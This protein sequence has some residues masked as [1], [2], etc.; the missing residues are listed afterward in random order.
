MSATETAE[1]R[2][3]RENLE[4]SRY[5]YQHE[6]IFLW[7]RP[8]CL[9][10]VLG[11]ACNL[12]CI[13][14]YQAKNGDH[15]LRPAEIGRE[16]R[17]EF[18]ALYPYV[19]TL[20]VMGGEVLAM[21]GFSELVEDVG[22]A[23]SRPIL[24]ISTNGTLLDNVWAEKMVRLPFQ[25][26]TVS[27]DA[28]TSG[29][30]MKLRGVDLEVILGG[31]GRLREWKTR[32]G[33]ELPHLN[34]FF[35]VMRSNFREIPAYLELM[36]QN[37]VL[38]VAFQ[39]M[40]INRENA[41]RRPWLDAQETIRSAEE[42]R[43]L[44]VILRGALERE[45]PL[46]RMIRVSGL[47]WLFAAHG[48][49]TSF[50]HEQQQGLYPNSDD[51][52]DEKAF[53]CCPNPWTT[54]FVAENGGVHLCFISEPIANIYEMPL[55]E[56]W[57]SP[58]AIAKRSHMLAGRYTASGCSKSLCGWRDG[59]PATARDKFQG[60][61]A[62]MAELSRH[63]RDVQGVAE[64]EPVVAQVRRAFREKTQSVAELQSRFQIL[65]ETNGEVHR[66]GQKYIDQLEARINEMEP[67]RKPALVRAAESIGRRLS[68]WGGGLS[69]PP[70]RFRAGRAG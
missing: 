13:H 12:D 60:S 69:R 9:G 47:E 66:F 15:L 70:A 45:R 56:I 57:N 50:L 65:C 68:V 48:L 28:A 20:R 43:E 3:Y 18:A 22:A 44:H 26:V 49:E 41:G 21:R 6:R 23:V 14:C 67:R 19:S 7:S 11:N 24:S 16:L 63:A 35:V 4:L 40:D 55:A 53:E 29:T 34:S 46:F 5:E 58:R 31:I 59:R 1:E 32:L 25:A 17:R 64:P 33:S 37:G 51:L 30:M 8:R 38:D 54:L 39:T 10:I 61:M 62:E 36:R 42:V 2:V 27:I 52:A